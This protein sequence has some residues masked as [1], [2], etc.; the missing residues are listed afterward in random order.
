MAN[1]ITEKQKKYIKNDYIIRVFSLALVVPISLLGIFLLA[2]II[3][4]YIAVN[5]KD[6][7]VAE[8]FLS[9]INI[10]NKENIGE[11]VSQVVSRTLDKIKVIELYNKNK[12]NPSVYFTEIISKKNN[13]IRISKISFSTGQILVSGISKNREGLVNFIDDLKSV[14]MFSAVDSPVS[15]FAKDSDIS[16][17]LN[18][19]IVI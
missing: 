8:Q 14:D 15:D 12:T 18:I 17:N 19:K 9:V 7:V 16:F 13:N 2:Y 1:L 6:K 10:E 4:Y 3:P 11:S 5:K